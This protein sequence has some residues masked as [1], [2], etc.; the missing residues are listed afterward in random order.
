MWESGQP[1]SVSPC[2]EWDADVHSHVGEFH[3]G[4]GP[5]NPSP[6]LTSASPKIKNHRDSGGGREGSRGRLLCGLL[7]LRGPKPLPCR[8]AARVWALLAVKIHTNLVY[9]STSVKVPS[10]ISACTH[11]PCLRFKL[12]KGRWLST[13]PCEVG[14]VVF[15]PWTTQCQALPASRLLKRS[16]T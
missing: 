14:A 12:E 3:Q 13:F 9:S 7:R 1:A 11:S 5:I 15:Q 4:F 10:V 6:S 2:A 16:R 8:G